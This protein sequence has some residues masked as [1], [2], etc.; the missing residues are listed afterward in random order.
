M[1][2]H[3]NILKL[4]SFKICKISMDLYGG[5]HVGGHSAH[6]PFQLNG[7]CKNF[8]ANN[9]L[10]IDPNGLKCVLEAKHIPKFWNN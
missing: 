5:R 3:L 2:I 9:S 1:L 6:L 4:L 7:K 8:H 10:A